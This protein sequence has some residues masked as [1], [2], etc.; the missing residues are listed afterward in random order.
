MLSVLKNPLKKYSVLG[1]LVEILLIFSEQLFL[2]AET[3]LGL[4]QTSMIDFFPTKKLD[5]P[6]QN[7]Y[8][9][10][11]LFVCWTAAYEIFLFVNKIS[12]KS[13]ILH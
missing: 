6:L 10:V 1:V 8:A 12:L 4:S 9:T 2:R 3:Y 13:Q 11:L 7:P 5:T